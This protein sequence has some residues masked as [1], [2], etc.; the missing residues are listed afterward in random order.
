MSAAFTLLYKL[1]ATHLTIFVFN[2]ITI[3]QQ[4]VRCVVTISSDDISQCSMMKYALSQ[5]LQLGL[6]DREMLQAKP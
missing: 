5:T 6:L 1:Q 4:T 3:H 2:K